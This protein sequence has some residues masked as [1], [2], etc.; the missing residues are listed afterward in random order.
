[1]TLVFVVP[2]Q[3]T[4]PPSYAAKSVSLFWYP[5]CTQLMVTQSVCD[6]LI[7]SSP[8]SLW[9]SSESSDIVKRRFPRKHWSTFWTSS[10]VTIECR[11]WPPLSSTSV[12]PS[13]NFL[14]HSL[15]QLSLITLLLYTQHNQ[16]WILAVLCPYVWRKWITART[17]QL[18]GAAMIVSMFHQ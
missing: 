1:M 15:T 18:A 3:R 13:L 11:S 2:L 8:R 10:S 5:P 4:V 9:N 12:R 14:H 6:N 16:R 17:L 7:Q